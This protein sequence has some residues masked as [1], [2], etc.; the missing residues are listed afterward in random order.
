ML[1]VCA[2]SVIRV[3]DGEGSIRTDPLTGEERLTK[4][5]LER[6]GRC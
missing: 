3:H 6:C 5:K 1:R 4:V 2:P